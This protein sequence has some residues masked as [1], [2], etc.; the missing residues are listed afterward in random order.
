MPSSEP[1][2]SDSNLLDLWSLMICF[3]LGHTQQPMSWTLNFCLSCF[4]FFFLMSESFLY[5]YMLPGKIITNLPCVTRL[6]SPL[7]RCLTK[8]EVTD[9]N[10]G[11]K[12]LPSLHIAAEWER[13]KSR[14]LTVVFSWCHLTVWNP[15]CQ[16][17]WMRLGGMEWP[18]SLATWDILYSMSQGSYLSCHLSLSKFPWFTRKTAGSPDFSTIALWGR[19]CY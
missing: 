11:A 10:L 13:E 18:D 7:S 15:M 14:N 5:L 17:L 3:Q 8:G 16:A 1:D 9:Q 4:F 2:F 12:L 6:P 19:C